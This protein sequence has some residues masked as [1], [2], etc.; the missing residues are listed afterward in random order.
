MSEQVA[1]NLRRLREMLG[2]TQEHLAEAAG[3]S[4]RT[5]QRAERN[6]ELS[7]ETLQGLAAVFDISVADLQRAWLSDEEVKEAIE[8]AAKRYKLIPLTRVER[9]SDRRPF[10][11]A[12]AW[13]V[14]HIAGLSEEQEDE[15]AVLEEL[16]RDYGDLWSDIGP[17]EQRDALK[18]IFESV[19]RLQAGGLCVAAGLDVMRLVSP[20]SREPWTMEVLRV[21]VSSAAEPRLTAFREKNRPVRFA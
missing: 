3:L 9:A 5:V 18:T 11:G 1:K 21:L 4:A 13:Q 19:D 2:W 16:L 14:D 7:A 15:I 17:T 12:H 8:E 10:M 6:G 20:A